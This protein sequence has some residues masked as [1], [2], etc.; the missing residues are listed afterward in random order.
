MA[1]ETGDRHKPFEDMASR[2]VTNMGE[3][4]GGAFV[5]VPPGEGDFALPKHVLILD[6]QQN[7]AAFWSMLQ[8]TCQVALQ[9]IERAASRQ[10]SAFGGR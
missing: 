9:E 3:G 10:H 2:I 5:I 8:T 7:P 6:G 4:F 1:E